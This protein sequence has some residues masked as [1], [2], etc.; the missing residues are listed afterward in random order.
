M[1]DNTLEILKLILNEVEYLIQENKSLKEKIEYFQTFQN[2]INTKHEELSSGISDLNFHLGKMDQQNH[3]RFELIDNDVSN[4]KDIK[5]QLSDI[6]YRLSEMDDDIDTKY[7]EL[8]SDISDAQYSFDRMDSQNND[9]FE[10]KDNKFET[11]IS[12]KHVKDFLKSL[13]Y[14]N[15]EG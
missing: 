5:S 9:I 4:I 13:S 2:D 6:K 1:I 8:S 14:E 15:N 3:K 10:E 12:K 7:E 11:F